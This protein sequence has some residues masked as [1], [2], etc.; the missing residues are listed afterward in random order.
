M[1]FLEKRFEIGRKLQDFLDKQENS[2]EK[3]LKEKLGMF[4]EQHNK[5][6]EK[7]NKKLG[8]GIGEFIYKAEELIENEWQ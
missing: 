3:E 4:F 2:S 8:G 1:G 7:I 5:E 6:M